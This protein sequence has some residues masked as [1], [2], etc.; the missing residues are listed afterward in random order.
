VGA[1]VGYAAGINIGRK[2]AAGC[3]AL[4]VLNPDV[5]LEPGALREMYVALD[6]PGVGV[7]VPMLLDSDGQRYPSLRREPSVAR[8][9]GDGLLGGRVRRRPGWLSEIIWSEEEYGYR[10]PVDWATGAALLVSTVCDQAVGDWDERFFL[11]S[12]EVDYAT[13]VR[14]AGFGVEYLPTARARHRGG[15][16]GRSDALVA[17]MA[18]NRIR[19][20]EKHARRSGAYHAVVVFNELLRSRDPAHRMALRTVMRRSSWSALPGG[21]MA[22]E[23][24]N[25][26]GCGELP[27]V[28]Q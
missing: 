20:M 23:G 6:E 28:A 12:E 26:A 2:R 7:V 16:S 10:H 5:V 15:G 19:Y 14:S 11:Y 22:Q 27:E 17:L 25:T 1:N 24:R 9:F 18:V 4:L 3:S 13:R 8:A 21:Q